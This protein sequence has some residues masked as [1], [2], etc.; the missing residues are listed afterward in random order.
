MEA[1]DQSARPRQG[2]RGEVRRGPKA[3]ERS[4]VAA[5]PKNTVWN[6]TFVLEA[7]ERS[8][9]SRDAAVAQRIIDWVEGHALLEAGFGGGARM[10]SFKAGVTDRSGWRS[11]FDIWTYGK[12]E[13]LFKYMLGRPPFDELERRRGLQERLNAIQGVRIAD[14]DLTMRPN[15]ALEVLQDEANLSEFFEVISWWSDRVVSAGIVK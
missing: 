7:I 12:V 9:G 11:C 2:N 8:K 10:G 4:S 6:R 3:N 15:I 1:R 5:A 14:E 13:I